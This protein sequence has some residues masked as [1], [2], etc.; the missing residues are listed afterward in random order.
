MKICTNCQSTSDESANFC[1]GYGINLNRTETEHREPPANN[2]N[3]IKAAV[4]STVLANKTLAAMETMMILQ[5]ELLAHLQDAPKEQ[6]IDRCR[7]LY[8]HQQI[9]NALNIDL[10][11]SAASPVKDTADD[12]STEID[13]RLDEMLMDRNAEMIID[14]SHITIGETH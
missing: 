3:Q 14:K 4:I 1:F 11:A 10:L 8:A 12:Q 13:M 5:A 7:Q 6:V 2:V 9:K